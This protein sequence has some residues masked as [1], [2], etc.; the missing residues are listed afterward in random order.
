MCLKEIEYSE[1][2]FAGERIAGKGA[3]QTARPRSVH[4]LGTAGNCRNRQTSAEGFCSHNN[5]RLDSVTIAGKQ[6]ARAA[7]TGLNL[8]SDEQHVVLAANFLK[9]AEVVLGRNDKSTFA[10]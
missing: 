6:R 1:S 5:V 9:N 3:A 10:Q 4:D 8:I 7:K 2:C